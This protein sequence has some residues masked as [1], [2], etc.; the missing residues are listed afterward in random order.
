MLHHRSPLAE[1]GVPLTAAALVAALSM[2]IAWSVGFLGFAVGGVVG[3]VV[4]V[5]VHEAMHRLNRPRWLV[6]LH[7]VHHKGYPANFGVT[8]PLWDIV[9]GTYRSKA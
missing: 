6:R 9:F 3:Y 4:Y 2:L 8:T 5:S 1:V 7:D